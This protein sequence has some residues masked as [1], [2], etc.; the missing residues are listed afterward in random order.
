[1]AK[2]KLG[3]G[4]DILIPKELDSSLL[5]EDKTR[6]QKLLISDIKPNPDQPRGQIDETRLAELTSS[7]KRHGVLQPIIVVRAKA[8]NGYTAI[9]VAQLAEQLT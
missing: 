8:G 4:L 6:V 2:A 9:F 1:M 5:E 7:I 3:R